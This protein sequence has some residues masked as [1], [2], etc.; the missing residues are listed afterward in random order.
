MKKPNT[1]DERVRE[2]NRAAAD[3]TPMAWIR[4]A[5]FPIAIGFSIGKISDC[6]EKVN[7]V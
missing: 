3:P 1:P 2:R 7:P 5:R 4:T 6:L